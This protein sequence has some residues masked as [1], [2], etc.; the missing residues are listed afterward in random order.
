MG[1]QLRSI[2]PT[3]TVLLQ[4]NAPDAASLQSSCTN[5]SRQCTTT[6]VTALAV[7]GRGIEGQR[8]SLDPGSADGS[9]RRRNTTIPIIS[10]AY[11]G[12]QH[13]KTQRQVA[14]PSSAD[15]FADQYNRRVA[16][17]TTRQHSLSRAWKAISAGAASA[18]S[19]KKSCTNRHHAF[20][21]WGQAPQQAEL[22]KLKSMG[23]VTVTLLTLVTWHC[24]L[25]AYDCMTAT[26]RMCSWEGWHWDREG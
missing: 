2:V 21:S 14:A 9:Y 18:T 16:D 20:R 11:E 17:D 6:D 1:R 13:L 25:P 12:R 4:P 23:D 26:L 22:V 8:P 7:V 3:T 19:T 10:A 15:C 5:N 24:G